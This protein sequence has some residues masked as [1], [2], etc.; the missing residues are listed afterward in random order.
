[1]T[2]QALRRLGW[3]VAVIVG[4]SVGGFPAPGKGELPAAFQ[5]GLCVEGGPALEECHME[6]L[7]A[8]GVSHLSLNPFG[9]MQAPDRPAMRLATER[10]SGG[11]RGRWWGESDDGLRHYA[12][13]ARAAGLEVMLR[14]HIWLSNTTD[15]H[16]NANLWL[17][18]IGFESEQEWAEFFSE[19][20]RF[21]LHYARLAEETKMEWLS[22][23]AELTRASREHPAEWR[24]IIAEVREIYK[25]KLIYSAN[26]W[27]EV[28]GVTFW[29]ALDAIGVQAYFPL[30][31]SDDATEEQLVEAWRGHLRMLQKLS[32]QYDKPV[33]FTEV[34]YRSS[35]RAAIEPWEW[36][37]PGPPREDLQAMCYRATFRAIEE[38]DCVQGMYWWKYHVVACPEEP[39]TERRV[40]DRL[41]SSFTW[42]G[43]QA[44]GVLR[45]NYVGMA[46]E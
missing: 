41:A 44:E 16:G 15:R 31:A 20:R 17:A 2:R 33:I 26:H 10:R 21:I 36:R 30:A 19:Y 22:V 39:G 11:G 27:Q 40:S 24:A 18:D 1:M 45:E 13:A 25:G 46:G 37:V 4:L 9:W 3:A 8:L 34:G 5:R 32:E 38:F 35:A 43:K 23:G 12:Q 14:P 6:E 7:K 29:D 42:Q 28:E